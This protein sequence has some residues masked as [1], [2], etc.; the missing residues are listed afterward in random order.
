MKVIIKMT[1]IDASFKVV[2]LYSSLKSEWF[3]LYFLLCILVNA[4]IRITVALK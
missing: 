3:I 4:K 1:L 2:K